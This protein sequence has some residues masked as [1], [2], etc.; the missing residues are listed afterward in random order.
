MKIAVLGAGHLGKIHIN[1]IKQIKDYTLIGFYDINPETAKKVSKD[2]N[3]KAYHDV[4]QLIKEADVVDVVTPTTTHFEYAS[5]AIKQSK[6]VFIEK[7]VSTNTSEARILMELATEAD[8]KVQVGH[9]ERFNPAFLAAKSHINNPLFIEAHRMARYNPRGCDV[10]VIMDLMI[11]DIDIVLSLIKSG[12]KKISASG[13]PVVSDTVDIANARLEFDNGAVA[14]ITASRISMNNLRKMRL[15]Q[16]N[17]YISIDFFNKET[18]IAKLHEINLET[19]ADEYI[20][21]TGTGKPTQS[22]HLDQ[23]EIESINAIKYQL[24]LF[25]QTILA[26]ETPAVSIH[27]AT[28]ALSIGEQIMDKIS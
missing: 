26:N 7:P 2:M 8:V 6:D 12:I 25:R 10:P 17:T 27:D 19:P 16:K 24:D 28:Y 4:D 1:C 15:F 14:N 22:I 9:V 5:K 21:E 18:S 23:L 20:I 3:V 13:I 11:H